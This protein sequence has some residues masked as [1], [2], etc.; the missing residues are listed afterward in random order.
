MSNN[1]QYE[2]AKQPTTM[3]SNAQTT[4]VSQSIH[5]PNMADLDDFRRTLSDLTI[6]VPLKRRFIFLAQEILTSLCLLIKGVP[7]GVSLAP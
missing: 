3:A 1:A 7:R 4:T 5:L 6:V 2:I